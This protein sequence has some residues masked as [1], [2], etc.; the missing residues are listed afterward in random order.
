MEIQQLDME[1]EDQK[2]EIIKLEQV[3][4]QQHEEKSGV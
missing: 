4:E 2:S 1:I 3:M